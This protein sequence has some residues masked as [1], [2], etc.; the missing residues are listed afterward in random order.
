MVAGPED[1]YDVSL[2]LLR[3]V[4]DRSGLRTSIGLLEYALWVVGASISNER[5]K[6]P[7]HLGGKEV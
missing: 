6:S 4:V 1:F 3:Y 7:G 5:R 2:C